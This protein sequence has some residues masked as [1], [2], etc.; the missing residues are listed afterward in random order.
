M[1][2]FSLQMNDKNITIKLDTLYRLFDVYE[3]RIYSTP[4]K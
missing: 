2:S 3:R 4:R 1:R